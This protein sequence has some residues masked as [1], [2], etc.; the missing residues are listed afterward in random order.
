MIANWLAYQ[1]LTS[2]RLTTTRTRILYVICV[3]NIQHIVNMNAFLLNKYEKYYPSYSRIKP[4]R[5]L[6]YWLTLKFTNV[7]CI[8]KT[9]NTRSHNS[10]RLFR[11]ILQ[12]CNKNYIHFL[13]YEMCL[14]CLIN[15]QNKNGH[16][17]ISQRY[18]ST[19]MTK[20]RFPIIKASS[21]QNMNEIVL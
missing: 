19:V 21:F 7:I 15:P 8:F 6:Q 3:P 2:V 16:L 10:K 9:G 14:N 17:G 1:T 18:S 13:I 12:V 5:L 11:T 4:Y 20:Y